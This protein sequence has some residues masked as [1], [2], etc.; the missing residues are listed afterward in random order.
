MKGCLNIVVLF[1][2]I[3]AIVKGCKACSK[4]SEVTPV[5]VPIAPPITT[6]PT[7]P[8]VNGSVS[9]DG[10]LIQGAPAITNRKTIVIRAKKK[11]GIK[12]YTWSMGD[13]TEYSTPVVTHSYEKDGTYK[14]TLNI[15]YEKGNSD[16][17]EF[18]IRVNTTPPDLILSNVSVKAQYAENVSDLTTKGKLMEA[19]NKLEPSAVIDV[20]SEGG[21]RTRVQVN[22]TEYK[23]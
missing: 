20:T 7:I 4:E 15:N 10:P 17:A 16:T 3:F 23:Q 11:A 13:G 21:H 12:G 1:L 5:P 14:I 22:V 6:A 19:N 2:I 8:V 18:T 9:D